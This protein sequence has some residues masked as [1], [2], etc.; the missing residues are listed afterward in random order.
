MPQTLYEKLWQDHVVP[1]E[2][3]ATGL[4][5]QQAEREGLDECGGPWSVRKWLRRQRLPGISA[6]SGR[7]WM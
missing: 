5:N 2:A 4:I 1:Q 3:D 6:M 7:G